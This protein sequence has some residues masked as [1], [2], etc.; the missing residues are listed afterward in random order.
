MIRMVIP[1][2]DTIRRFIICVN[3]LLYYF[4]V[5]VE[6]ESWLP[7]G[8]PLKIVGGA[9]KEQRR[10]CACRMDPPVHGDTT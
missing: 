5:A 3:D 9:S 10:Q 8:V 1:V 4:W 2:L 6:G 7:K